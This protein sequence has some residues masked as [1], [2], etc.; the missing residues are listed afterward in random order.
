MNMKRRTFAKTLTLLAAGLVLPVSH[1]QAKTY[2]SIEQ[3]RAILWGDTPMQ[4]VELTLTKDQRK[5]IKNI[6][7][8]RVR[9]PKMNLWKTESGGWFIIDQIIG[10]HENID[11]AF[12]LD[13][14]GKVM[15]MEILTYRETYG[16]QVNNPKWRAQFLGLGH[17]EH[18]KLDKQ[19]KNISGATLSCRHITDGVNR[20]TQT[21]L[22]V[23]R[24]L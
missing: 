4:P 9:N 19:I 16:F 11:M 1:S 21:W 13:S 6:A 22:Q 3:A 7:K 23:L 17:T 15:G 14:K 24:H 2:L 20:L 8:V 10:K 5:S 12:A 18:L